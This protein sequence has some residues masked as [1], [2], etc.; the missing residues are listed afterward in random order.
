MLQPIVQAVGGKQKQ[1]QRLGNDHYPGGQR[2][3][4]ADVAA[5]GLHDAAGI[6]GDA[7]GN[8]D[9]AQQKQHLFGTERISAGKGERLQPVGRNEHAH[10]VGNVVGAQ[11]IGA[12]SAGQNKPCPG[13]KI[14][15]QKRHFG[16]DDD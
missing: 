10:D 1:Y 14:L 9:G 6:G 2:T 3:H 7:Y 16:P 4:H 11:G 13:I 15:S 12:E 5:D 8:G